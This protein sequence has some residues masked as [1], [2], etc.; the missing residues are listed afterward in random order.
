MS[1]IAETVKRSK[2]N[3]GIP[4]HVEALACDPVTAAR[5]RYALLSQFILIRNIF[6][7]GFLLQTC[8]LVWAKSPTKTSTDEEGVTAK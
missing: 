7:A 6:F 8:T 2:A 3:L 5:Y 4:H 1:R